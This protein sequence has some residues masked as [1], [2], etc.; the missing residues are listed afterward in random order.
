[1]VVLNV[2]RIW[3]RCNKE[4]IIHILI[5]DIIKIENKTKDNYSDFAI[6]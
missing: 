5:R 4:N 6:I 3:V 2:K 1:M